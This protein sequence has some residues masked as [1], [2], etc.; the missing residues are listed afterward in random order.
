M[1]RYARFGQSAKYFFMFLNMLFQSRSFNRNNQRF[2]RQSYPFI[3]KS[4]RLQGF[5]FKVLTVK[6]G[7]TEPSYPVPENHETAV[8]PERFIDKL[9]TM[10]EY[11]VIHMSVR[12]KI[13]T[14]KLGQRVIFKTSV[15]GNTHPSACLP[16]MG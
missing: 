11:E 1:Q 10:A 2:I 4:S 3:D 5:D 16:A 14:R 6:H 9:V 12:D 15:L 8:I 13:A 7:I